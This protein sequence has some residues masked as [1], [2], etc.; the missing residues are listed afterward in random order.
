MCQGNALKKSEAPIVARSAAFFGKQRVYQPATET[1]WRSAQNSAVFWAP[2][3]SS[4]NWSDYLQAKAPG[5]YTF[6]P[7]LGRVLAQ[8]SVAKEI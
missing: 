7:T 2:N 6:N 3:E 1:R 5:H 8:F 4:Q